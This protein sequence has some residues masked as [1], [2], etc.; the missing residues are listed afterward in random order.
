MARTLLTDE[1]QDVNDI[2]QTKRKSL[3]LFVLKLDK[4]LKV[5]VGVRCREDML[6]PTK[7]GEKACSLWKG[8]KPGPRR[9]CLLFRVLSIRVTGCPVRMTLVICM[10]S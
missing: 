9:W 8:Q 5:S 7:G 10:Y 6:Y 3:F 1:N 4:E 2:P